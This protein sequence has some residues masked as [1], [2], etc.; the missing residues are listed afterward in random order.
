M[1]PKKFNN[2]G[3]I[4]LRKKFGNQIFE[5]KFLRKKIGNQNSEKNINFRNFF[6]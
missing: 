2:F 5:K 6:E 3:K 4:F 1:F